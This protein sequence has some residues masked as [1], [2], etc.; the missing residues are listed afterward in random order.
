M[1]QAVRVTQPV[2]DKTQTFQQLKQQQSG[3]SNNLCK[4]YRVHPDVKQR[5]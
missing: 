5:H 4:D 1:R 2:H 3:I